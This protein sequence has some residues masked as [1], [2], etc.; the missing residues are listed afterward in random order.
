MWGTSASSWRSIYTG[1]IRAVT[2][3]GYNV[4]GGV[5]MEAVGAKV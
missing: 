2:M 4:G 5:G 3:W 1:V